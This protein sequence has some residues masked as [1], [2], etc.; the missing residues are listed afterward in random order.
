[1]GTELVNRTIVGNPRMPCLQEESQ[2][3]MAHTNEEKESNE[4]ILVSLKGVAD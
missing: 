1:M 4:A 2:A 3:A